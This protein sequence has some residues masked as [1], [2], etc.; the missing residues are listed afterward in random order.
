[1]KKSALDSFFFKLS[2]V[3]DGFSRAL[4]KNARPRVRSARLEILEARELLSVSVGEYAAIRNAYEEFALP[5]SI[6]DVNVIEIRAEDLSVSSLKDAIELAGSTKKDDLIVARTTNDINVVSFAKPSDQLTIELDQDIFGK[7]TI[8]ALGP[9]QLVVDAKNLA[10]TLTLAAGSLNLGNVVLKNGNAANYGGV[11]FNKGELTLKNCAISGGTCADQDYGSNA[12]SS[13]SLIAINSSITN[14]AGGNAVYATGATSFTNCSIESNAGVGVYVESEETATFQNVSI[15]KN[16]SYGLVNKYGF[17]QLSECELSEN[18]NAGLLNSGDV[19]MSQCVVSYNGGAGV[20]NQSFQTGETPFSPTISI[21]RTKIIG[22]AN[23]KGAGVYNVG[24]KL[25]LSN[26]EISQNV[27]EESGGGVYC[28]F[29]QGYNNLSTIV[30]CT[31]AGNAA[32]QGGGLYSETS[33]GLAL[34]NS[35]VSMNYAGELDSNVSGTFTSRNNLVGA[36]ANFIVPP[37]F[38]YSNGRLTN[39]QSLNLRLA[40]GSAAHNSGD[41]SRVANESQDLDGNPRI[42]GKSVDVGAYEY[43]NAGQ[44]EFA[45]QYVVTTLEDS[46][47]PFDD[48]TSLRE[49]IFFA[50]D[51]NASITFEDGLQGVLKLNSQLIVASPIAINGSQRITVDARN[52]SRAFL[53][54]APLTL[55]GLTIVNGSTSGNGGL[56]HAK[57]S[58]TIKN[59]TLDSGKCGADAHGGL[60][61]ASQ[62]FN[63]NDVV[64]TNSKSDVALYL[65]GI[66]SLTRCEVATSANDA[67]YSG[68]S[69]TAKDSSVFQ[70][71]GRG[72]VNYYGTIALDNVDVREQTGAGIFNV[73]TAII[74]NSSIRDNG[75]SGLVNHSFV[76]SSTNL[77]ISDARIKN[78]VIRN[79]VAENGAGI[80]NRFG[81]VDLVNCEIS[82]NRSVKAGGG[83]Y[84]EVNPGSANSVKV[85]NCTIAGNYAGTNGGG[86]A[87]S[88]AD[89]L[90]ILYNSIVSANLSGDLNSNVSCDVS[91]SSSSLIGSAPGFVVAPVFDYSNKTLTNADSINLRLASNSSAINAGSFSYVGSENKTDLD[92]ANR[93]YGSS[94][95]LGAYEYQGTPEIAPTPSYVVTTLEDS[96]NPDDGKTS[97]REALYWADKSGQTISFASNLKGTI[98]LT[99]QLVVANDIAINGDSRITISGQGKTRVMLN[100]AN[101]TLK[102][103]A[104]TN[105]SANSLGNVVY[106]QGK[107]TLENATVSNGKSTQANDNGNVY[108]LDKLTI[109]NSVVANAVTGA[110]VYA[111][112]SVVMTDSVVENNKT[113]GLYVADVAKLTNCAI[114]NNGDSGVFNDYGSVELK[115]VVISGNAGTGLTNRGSASLSTCRV[116]NNGSSGLF[117]VSEIYSDSARFSSSLKVYSS[118]VKGNASATSGAGVYNLGGSLEL[119]NS[120]VSANTAQDYGGGVYNVFLQSC[121]N[122]TNIVNCTVSGNYAGNQGGGI[123]VDSNLFALNIYNSIVAKNYS[124]SPNANVEGVVSDSAR[125]ILA[126]NPSFVVAPVFSE[127]GVLQNKDAIDLHLNRDSVAVDFGDNE[128]VVGAVDVEGRDRV[129]N[130]AVDLGA[131]EYF[132]EGS[133]RVTT[134]NDSFDLNDDVVSL[135]EALYFAKNGDVVSFDPS[136]RGSIFLSTP[137]EI[138]KDVSIIGGGAVTINGSGKVQLVKNYATVSISG[139]AFARGYSDTSAGAIYNEGILDVDECS[140]QYNEGKNGGAIYNRRNATA[141][142]ANSV[143]IG[144]VA[145]ASGGSVYNADELTVTKSRFTNNDALE[146]GG[147]IYCSG[148]TIIVNSTI[149]DSSAQKS[150]GGLYLNSGE[151]TIVNAT[152][153][154]NNATS[155][156]GLY[157][158]GGSALLYNDVVAKNS[159]DVEGAA[160]KTTADR[161]LSSFSFNNQAGNYLYNPSKPLFADAENGDYRLA[162]ESQAIDKGSSQYAR[163]FGIGAFSY[164]LAGSPRYVGAEIDLGA[165]ESDGAVDVVVYENCAF[166]LTV[167]AEPGDKVF[168]DLSGTG[169]GEFVETSSDFWVEAIK[170][171]FTPGYYYLRSKIVGKNGNVKAE[172]ASTLQVLRAE[173][174]VSVAVAPPI[175]DEAIVLSFDARFLGEIPVHSWRVDWGDG[176]SIIKYVDSFT[177][178]NFYARKDSDVVYAINLIL[179]GEDGQDEQVYQATRFVVPGDRDTNSDAFLDYEEAFDLELGQSALELVAERAMLE[180]EA[181]LEQTSDAA[182]V[183]LFL[184]SLDQ[185]QKKRK[186]PGV[187]FEAIE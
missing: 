1:M 34:Y 121:V 101:L 170:Q 135:R 68:N 10:R 26:C 67:V 129:F 18:G 61:W 83:V 4:K 184:P 151:L 8:V 134:L 17:V 110:G 47:D 21:D 178:G 114:Q 38:D 20:V 31:I 116:L 171:G 115:N 133:T 96:F 164:D 104:L 175:F 107:L 109:K 141:T 41:S 94:V 185:T 91:L 122:K 72:I 172:N 79:N 16:G 29:L 187:C 48:V 22:N 92:G 142:I 35:I 168:W 19:E 147:A 46:F 136:L 53:V 30:N 161:V 55:D 11:L 13:G 7:T 112:G 90:L 82:A 12:R 138:V 108:A 71:A 65:L 45:P 149:A 156:G 119:D 6:N 158:N 105:G 174:L 15:S 75:D 181:I 56:I 120:E 182:L 85:T 57:D 167:E 36:S 125:N 37:I 39:G 139:L 165:Y 93:V 70:N 130:N 63:A 155:G 33:F 66:S 44:S 162:V 106:S 69:L 3:D 186:T 77:F 127:S 180:Q 177:V 97:L 62:A 89:A 54:E 78:T 128:Y 43:R 176:T 86:V 25:S 163:N 132:T 169:S 143:F 40:Y 102:N 80:Y 28:E 124:T 160:A 74:E 157:I 42:Y 137:I 150:G 51:S 154:G 84:N 173:P 144:N 2:Q 159:S 76:V 166:E 73:G 118:I 113:N 14:A 111:L 50:D 27:A 140:F 95:D 145:Q 52:K 148:Q 59:S 126:G 64:F 49:A 60:V 24:G 183:E 99:S 58:L 123:Y 98:N 87:A 23:V 153:A 81:L 32:K 100:E 146:N 117:N 88:Q 5:A 179:V 152:I 9:K 131:Y 103:I